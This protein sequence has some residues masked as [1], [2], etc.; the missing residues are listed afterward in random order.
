MND[1]RTGHASRIDEATAPKPIESSRA[2]VVREL[3]AILKDGPPT[4][5]SARLAALEYLW[6]MTD[7]SIRELALEADCGVATVARAIRNVE[8][9]FER[10]KQQK[11]ERP[12][13]F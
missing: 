8:R 11:T 5:M 2:E 7:L 9:H 3:V 10:R 1:E 6:R 13:H 4:G 12:P